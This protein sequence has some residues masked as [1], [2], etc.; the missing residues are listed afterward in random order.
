MGNITCT[1]LDTHHTKMKQSSACKKQKI[2]T[3]KKTLKKGFELEYKYYM[4]YIYLVLILSIL[5][6]FFFFLSANTISAM[7]LLILDQWNLSLIR[8]CSLSLAAKKKSRRYYKSEN[9]L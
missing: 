7:D 8:K 4:A 6:A 1:L 9:I 2:E 5:Q 3:I